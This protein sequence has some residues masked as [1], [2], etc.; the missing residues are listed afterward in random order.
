MPNWQI[1]I[2]NFGKEYDWTIFIN[3]KL[4][5]TNLYSD[6]GFV[7][8]RELLEGTHSIEYTTFYTTAPC[9]CH[10]M[11]K[12]KYHNVG[13]VLKYHNV[14]TVLKYHTV[15]T[16]LNSNRKTKNTTL[17]EQFQTL[18]DKQKIPHCRNSS[19]L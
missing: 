6:F 12:N 7:S 10:K 13:T 5:L 14:G 8:C 18:I 4:T 11:K 19:K 3:L 1:W 16:V 15:G 17:S 2:G 9:Y